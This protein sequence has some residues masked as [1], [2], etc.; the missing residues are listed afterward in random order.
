MGAAGG[1]SH[2]VFISG[3]PLLAPI[4]Y[5]F[6][7]LLVTELARA[8]AGRI[9]SV[10]ALGVGAIVVAG[11]VG[12]AAIPYTLEAGLHQGSANLYFLGVAVLQS[13][14]GFEEWRLRWPPDASGVQR[15]RPYRRSD[16]RHAPQP[17]GRGGRHGSKHTGRLGVA[18]FR[19]A[20]LLARGPQPRAGGGSRDNETVKPQASAHPR[21][22]ER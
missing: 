7:V 10:A 16:L 2:V 19:G 13:M 6:L 11:S 14:I 8:G 20:H 9:Y 1:W 5:L 4:R 22:A 12:I 21:R 18:R 3:M 15:P 17:G